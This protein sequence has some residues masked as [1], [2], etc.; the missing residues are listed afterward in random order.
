M[1]HRSLYLFVLVGLIILV[2]FSLGS[3]IWGKDLQL[4]SFI[5]KAY[6]TVCHQIPGRS[7]HI[8]DI[9][10]AVNTRCFGV[11]TGLLA[12]WAIIPFI[13]ATANG[14]KWPYLFLWLAVIIQI[15]DY[16]GN[17]FEI[18]ENTNEPRFILG[19]IL[20][21]AVSLFLSDL[22]STNNQKDIQYG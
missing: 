15:T 5:Y 20:G 13:H 17:L 12:G 21:L 18:W 10:M 11:F 6:G 14:K 1:R 7:F 2:I 4:N 19:N 16:S 3:G 22:F 8:N 9:Q